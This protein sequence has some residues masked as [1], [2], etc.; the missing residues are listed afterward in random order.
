MYSFLKGQPEIDAAQRSALHRDYARFRNGLPDSLEDYVREQYEIDLSSEYGN[1]FIKNPFGKGSGQLSL[2]TSQVRRDCED[3][4]GFVV[5]KSIIAEDESGAQSMSEWAI[6]ETRMVVE[7]ITANDGTEGWTVS[8]KGR[9][10]YDTFEE[11]L[12]FF[13]E[14]LA[15]A[16]PASV[17][18]VPSCKYHLPRAGEG[19]WKVGE[20]EYTTK[21]LIEVWHRHSSEAMPIEKDFSPTLAGSDR[22]AQAEMIIEWL[23]RVTSLIRR[24][25]APSPVNI[26]L[27][28]F[29][30]ILDDDFQLEMLRAVNENCSDSDTPDFL[31]YA[32]RLF[33]S[34][35][36]FDGVRGIAYGGPDLSARNLVVLRRMRLLERQGAIPVCKLPISATGNIVSGRIAAEYLLRGASS[37]QIHTFFQLPSGEYTMKTG[38]KTAR[39]LLEL[40]FHPAEGLLAWLLHL[41]R[42]FEWP[43]EWNIK[44]MAE[45]CMEPANNVWAEPASAM[46]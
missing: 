24:G 12:T 1:T 15:L 42:V 30:A 11:Y 8:W 20:Y 18:V 37:F 7:R 22:A 23:T 4:L 16:G 40:Y 6:E 41:R 2:N 38:G 13:D 45:F 27:K 31:V 21:R 35:R 33:D 32:N 44:Q 17:L 19:E 3:G 29:N 34:N 36:E 28:I 43:V 25:A 39:A 9:G 14:A 10:W 26:G 5:L 46:N